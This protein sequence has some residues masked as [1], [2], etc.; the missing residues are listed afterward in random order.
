VAEAVG[1]L[2]EAIIP[3]ETGLLVRPGDEAAFAA[4]ILAL[5][6]DPARR[7]ALGARA[8]A[9]LRARLTWSHLA[10]TAE[11]AYQAVSR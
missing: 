11:Q 2:A 3:G 8:A 10:A 7:R 6:D 9:D 5:L 1:Q 4:A